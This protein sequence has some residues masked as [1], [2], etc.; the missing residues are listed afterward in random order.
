MTSKFELFSKKTEEEI[1]AA[2]GNPSKV[3]SSNDNFNEYTYL[4]PN[5]INKDYQ[6]IELT[7]WKKDHTLAGVN[8]ENMYSKEKVNKPNK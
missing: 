4:D 3:D 5:S 8:I 6:E 7:I 2:Y 1:T